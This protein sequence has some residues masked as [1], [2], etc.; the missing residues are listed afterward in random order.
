MHEL[1]AGAT[2]RMF[3][4]IHAQCGK[5]MRNETLPAC[6]FPL[7]HF[8]SI[9]GRQQ[10]ETQNHQKLTAA[11]QVAEITELSQPGVGE[12]VPVNIVERT[13]EPRQ[14][15]VPFKQPRECKYERTGGEEEGGNRQE[16]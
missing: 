7:R 2:N 8:Y 6:L 4:N 13:D 11:E 15:Y 9:P 1:G 5:A 12:V 3:Q 16:A 14:R 10:H